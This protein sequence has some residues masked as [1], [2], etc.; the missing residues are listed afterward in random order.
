[1]NQKLVPVEMLCLP[2]GLITENTKNT[3]NT[4]DSEN[5]K[6]SVIPYDI[7]CDIRNCV[8]THYVN[9]NMISGFNPHMFGYPYFYQGKLSIFTLSVSCSIELLC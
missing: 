5:Q 7:S 3:E 2:E 4:Q 1:M 9:K 8:S 6:E